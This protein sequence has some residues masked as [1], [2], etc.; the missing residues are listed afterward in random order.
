MRLMRE[1]AGGAELTL[2]LTPCPDLAFYLDSYKD[3]S[4]TPEEEVGRGKEG[5]S[6]GKMVVMVRMESVLLVSGQG[7]C[8]FAPWWW[9]GVLAFVWLLQRAW[10]ARGYTGTDG[11]EIPHHPRVWSQGPFLINSSYLASICTAGLVVR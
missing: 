8:S 1:T 5:P 2:T 11:D 6:R 10:R 4:A 3:Q 9:W 7:I